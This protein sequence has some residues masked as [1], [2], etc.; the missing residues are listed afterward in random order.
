MSILNALEKSKQNRLIENQNK[1][2]PCT[3]CGCESFE[4]RKTTNSN[5]DECYPYFCRS[6][7]YRLPITEKK[8]I[9]LE[10]LEKQNEFNEYHVLDFKNIT[11]TDCSGGNNLGF[12][13]EQIKNGC[14]VLSEN[15]LIELFRKVIQSSLK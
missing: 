7:G 15:D 2:K 10:I 11:I 14:P 5:G 9:A 12:Y 6:C 13:I 1:L 3:H 4:L 8:T